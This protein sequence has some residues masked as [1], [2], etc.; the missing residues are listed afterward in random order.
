MELPLGVT[1]GVTADGVIIMIHGH[2]D[3]SSQLL[4]PPLINTHP[5][6]VSLCVPAG[7]V[8]GSAVLRFELELVSIQKGVPEGY[9]FIWLDET[10][11]DIFEAMDINQDKEVPVE[12]VPHTHTLSFQYNI[13]WSYI[14]KQ[15]RVYGG[16]VK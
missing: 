4:C 2:T 8:P 13:N 11:K 5:N 15:L 1:D 7:S 12:E 16:V 9:L 10:P 3:I 14:F 6:K